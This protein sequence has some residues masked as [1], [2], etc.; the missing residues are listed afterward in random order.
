MKKYP[1][2]F[3]PLIKVLFILGIVLAV[4]VIV[5]NAIKFAKTEVVDTYSYITLINTVVVSV[6]AL[7]LLFSIL[8]NSKFILDDTLLTLRWGFIKNQYKIVSITKLVKLDASNKLILY[9][10]DENYIVVYIA[11]EIFDEFSKDLVEKN[12]NIVVEYTNG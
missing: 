12:K 8:F 7:V 10:D 2:K 4:A 9:Y 11:P 6:F 1:Y 3:T 5:V